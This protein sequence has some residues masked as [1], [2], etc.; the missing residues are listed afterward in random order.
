[1]S[2]TQQSKPKPAATQGP[3][4]VTRYIARTVEAQEHLSRALAES[5]KWEDYRRDAVR[6][7]FEAGATAKELADALKISR[8]KIYQ[9]IGSDRARKA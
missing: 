3:G 9:L 6:Q 4:T 5:R 7:S 8:A 2:R 1:M